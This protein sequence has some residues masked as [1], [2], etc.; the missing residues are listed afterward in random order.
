MSLRVRRVVT[1]H[2]AQGRAVVVGDA[3]MANATSPRPGLEG[4]VVW[5]SDRVPVDNL[6]PGDG[7]AKTSGVTLPGGAVFRVVRYAPGTEGRMH[8]TRTLDHG[9]VLSGAVALELDDGVEVT[10]GAGDVL[11]QRGTIH[12]WANRGSEPC[13]VA[14]FILDAEPLPGDDHH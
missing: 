9:V 11:V 10:L 4:C 8:R 12:K 5:A 7:A 14:F 13:T 3:V 6:E 2:D 1:G